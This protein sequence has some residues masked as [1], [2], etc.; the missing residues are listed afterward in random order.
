MLCLSN[1]LGRDIGEIFF[2]RD[3]TG[4]HF[5]AENNMVGINCKAFHLYRISG[6]MDGALNSSLVHSNNLP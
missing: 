5:P 4:Q 1:L 3:F 2:H 6:S